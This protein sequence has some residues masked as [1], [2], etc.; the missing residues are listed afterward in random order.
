MKSRKHCKRLA[1]RSGQL[2]SAVVEVALFSPFLLF[3]ALGTVDY[4]RVVHEDIALERAAYAGAQW[5]AQSSSAPDD[6]S[7]IKAAVVNDLGDEMAEDGVATSVEKYCT[8]PDESVIDCSSGTCSG[9]A[10]P[11]LYVRVQVAKEFTTLFDYPGIP[12]TISLTRE[13]RMRAR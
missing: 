1:E 8:C 5:G 4:G 2:G 9:S 11:Y 13:A 6:L 12:H 7:G 10:R 3:M